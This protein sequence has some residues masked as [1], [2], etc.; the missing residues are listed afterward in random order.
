MGTLRTSTEIKMHKWM[1]MVGNMWGF[2]GPE[3]LPNSRRTLALGLGAS[4]RNF[5]D[6]AV[7]GLGGVWFGKAVMLAT[8]GVLVAEEARKKDKSFQNIEAANA[9]EAL[10][11]LLAFEGNGWASDPRLRGSTK[12]DKISSKHFPFVSASQRKNYVTQP[13]RMSTVQTLP[14][15][16]LVNTESARFNA[17]RISDAGK[18]F[19][20]LCCQGFHPYKRS[21]VEHL[22]LWVRGET[23][24][25]SSETLRAALSP[26][27]QLPE[28]AR[29]RLREQVIQGGRESPKDKQRRRE[30][31]AW[32]ETLR[33]ATPTQIDWQHT[34]K[35]ISSDHWGD[36]IA[37]A[38]FFQAREAAIQVLHALEA[39]IGNQ[40]TGMS[41]SLKASI[42][43]SVL[44]HIEGLKKA[45]ADFLTTKHTDEAASAF[46]HECSQPDPSQVLRCLVTR[47][48][49]VLRLLGDDVKPGPAF[50]GSQAL[51][52]EA[53]AE[54]TNSPTVGSSRLPEGIS[55]R[56]Q[57]LFLLNADLHGQLDALLPSNNNEEHE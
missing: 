45:A 19:V 24:E 16:G 3:F 21:V 35:E 20:E 29:K 12:L 46:F 2:S 6:L 11:C 15:F 26:L 51:G 7:P 4:A 31:L 38:R 5:N 1:A 53:E 27:N 39:H 54:P 55:Y 34:P 49:N 22:S 37:G 13:M 43:E 52:N 40:A 57:N 28:I 25:D 23:N 50:S 17:F 14:A 47:D 48:G 44:P 9:I 8:L 33:G 32:V 18:E 41:Y 42:P 10:A 56:M 30:A 36:L